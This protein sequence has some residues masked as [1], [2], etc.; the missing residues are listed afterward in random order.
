MWST[1]QLPFVHTE[2]LYFCIKINKTNPP[3][4]CQRKKNCCRKLRFL[5]I[6]QLLEIVHTWCWLWFAISGFL[7]NIV[8]EVAIL[9]AL[10]GVGNPVGTAV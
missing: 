9:V 3:M 8:P 5:R 4:E 10:V 7:A 6:D 1:D 2:L